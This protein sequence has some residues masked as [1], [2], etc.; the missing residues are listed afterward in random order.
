MNPAV[1]E[2]LKAIV[3]AGP[4]VGQVIV[5]LIQAIG[6]QKPNN[7]AEVHA[8]I[9]KVVAMETNAPVPSPAVPV[10]PEAKPE[11]KGKDKS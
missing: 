9:T 3:A 4:V 11:P 6:G 8:E 2:V 5:E 7:A 10:K 1:L